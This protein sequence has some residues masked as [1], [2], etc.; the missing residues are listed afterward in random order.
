MNLRPIFVLL[1]ACA[2]AAGWVPAAV[3]AGDT[4]QK[5]VVTGE[6]SP[7]KYSLSVIGQPIAISDAS[8]VAFEGY[9]AGDDGIYTGS[10]SIYH[11]LIAR[12]NP[13]AGGYVSYI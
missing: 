8:Q 10:K 4:I 9:I 1:T 13:V 2:F 11:R 3:A 12:G 6:L 7:I 5:V